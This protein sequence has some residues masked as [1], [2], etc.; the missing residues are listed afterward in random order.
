MT[1][2]YQTPEGRNAILRIAAQ[3]HLSIRKSRKSPE[4]ETWHP[5]PTADLLAAATRRAR[6]LGWSDPISWLEDQLRDGDAELAR[7]IPA[8]EPDQ[9]LGPCPQRHT[10]PA[11]TR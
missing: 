8:G 9:L 5:Q 10:D 1:Q 4:R 2:P 6:E 11:P 7:R 3:R